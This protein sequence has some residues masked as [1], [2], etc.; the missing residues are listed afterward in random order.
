MIVSSKT[1]I[2]VTR[3]TYWTNWSEKV[4]IFYNATI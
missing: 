1:K 3:E 4:Y 2:G